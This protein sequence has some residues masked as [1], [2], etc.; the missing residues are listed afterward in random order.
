MAWSFCKGKPIAKQITERI[1]VDMVTG[2]ILPK[3]RLPEIEDMCSIT[4]ASAHS[5]ATAYAELT[6]CGIA[7]PHGKILIISDDMEPAI[8][9]RNDMAENI[10]AE[11]INNMASLGFSRKETLAVMG[12][13]I[14]AKSKQE[15]AE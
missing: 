12:K 11:Y 13:T 4:G 8:Q 9:K 10:T 1:A 7:I 14:I 2:A 5:V 15:S 6:E 3:Q